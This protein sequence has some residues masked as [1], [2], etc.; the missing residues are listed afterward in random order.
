[1]LRRLLPYL[2][3]LLALAS[4]KTNALAQSSCPGDTYL[5]WGVGLY[6]SP[7]TQLNVT[8]ANSAGWAIFPNGFTI[9]ADANFPTCSPNTWNGYDGATG[10]S[11]FGTMSYNDGTINYSGHCRIWVHLVPAVNTP[12]CVDNGKTYNYMVARI[13]I[14]SCNVSHTTLSN[15]Y[16]AVS[17]DGSYCEQITGA[18]CDSSNPYDYISGNYV[19]MQVSGF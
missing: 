11:C 18:P 4:L 19:T 7:T 6:P 17:C 5:G 2:L 8:F 14:Q 10:M 16:I 13:K 1:M 15:K 9:D 3:I 12:V